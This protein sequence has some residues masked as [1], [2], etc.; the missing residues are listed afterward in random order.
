MLVF[1]LARIGK[2]KQAFFRLIILEK[3]KDTHGDYLENLGS[4]NPHTNPPRAEF[5]VERIKHW[6]ERGA[7]ATS[8]VHNLFVEQKIIS[9][10]KLK[11][12]K[13]KKKTADEKPTVVPAEKSISAAETKTA[14]P[15]S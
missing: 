4:F 5:N 3:T 10:D 8:R 7:Q 2:K 12:W 6:L 1:K 13:P 9:A 11:V 14:A 15:I